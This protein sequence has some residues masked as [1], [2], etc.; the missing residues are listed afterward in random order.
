[1]TRFDIK[2][3]K[4]ADVIRAQFAGGG[5]GGSKS[6]AASKPADPWGLQDA[7]HDAFL[8]DILADSQKL[9]D[10][11]QAQS[12]AFGTHMEKLTEQQNLMQ[13]TKGRLDAV[14]KRTHAAEKNI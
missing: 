11:S 5:G 7:E 6:A 4:K 3:T 8:D 12:E 2:I 9:M 10:I 14:N 13:S 1:V